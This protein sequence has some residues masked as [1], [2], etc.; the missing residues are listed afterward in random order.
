MYHFI[1]DQSG[2]KNV[3]FPINGSRRECGE[4]RFFQINF[5]RKTIFSN[6]RDGININADRCDRTMLANLVLCVQNTASRISAVENKWLSVV[7]CGTTCEVTYGIFVNV[8]WIGSSIKCC[9]KE[10]DRCFKSGIRI[11]EIFP[12]FV[13]SIGKPTDNTFWHGAGKMCC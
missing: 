8:S 12:R 6:V 11:S 4:R 3:I 7:C 5:D 13:S 2:S 9:V 10:N 1:Y